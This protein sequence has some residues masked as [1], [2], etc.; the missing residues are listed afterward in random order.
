MVVEIKY[1]EV[2]AEAPIEVD[3]VTI[4]HGASW[5]TLEELVDKFYECKEPLIFFSHL[6]V[7]FGC[8]EKALI[9]KGWTNKYCKDNGKGWHAYVPALKDKCYTVRI[10]GNNRY[11]SQ[12]K[13]GVNGRQIK[14]YNA[15]NWIKGGSL[16]TLE[17]TEEEYEFLLELSKRDDLAATPASNA[18]QRLGRLPT[19][20]IK[21]LNFFSHYAQVYKVVL[22]QH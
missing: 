9:K 14:I 13:I 17:T 11:C 19:S 2:H 8:L 3:K 4:D 15:A 10:F 21:D 16:P 22:S 6:D 7:C 5:I 20:E 18:K 12:V 1:K